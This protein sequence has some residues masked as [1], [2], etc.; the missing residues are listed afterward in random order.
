MTGARGERR[1][2]QY[3]KSKGTKRELE[4]HRAGRCATEAGRRCWIDNPEP[5]P[6][7]PLGVAIQSFTATWPHSVAPETFRLRLPTGEAVQYLRVRPLQAGA[8]PATLEGA[9]GR[10]VSVSKPPPR[11]VAP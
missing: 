4:Q 8:G 10:M 3:R 6:S 11:P 7:F 1:R 5:D 9:T 2:W